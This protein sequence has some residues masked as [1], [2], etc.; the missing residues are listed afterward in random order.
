[1][2]LRL[3]TIEGKR[4]VT[5]VVIGQRHCTGSRQRNTLVSRT[6]QYIG[7]NAAGG[8]RLGIETP[9]PRQGGTATKQSGIE[10][11][12][13]HTARLECKLAEFQHTLFDGELDELTLIGLHT[14]R[15]VIPPVFY[16]PAALILYK[17][18]DMEPS[19]LS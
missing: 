16:E 1:M 5:P 4:Q 3:F 6:E 18:F 15:H 19:G 12:G 7:C 2:R 17:P 14:A 10:E 8:D 11:I 13:A 9:Q